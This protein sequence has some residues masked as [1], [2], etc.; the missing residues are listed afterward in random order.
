M[1]CQQGKIGKTKVLKKLEDIEAG[2]SGEGTSINHLY[3][4][5]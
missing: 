5:L 4:R 1:T 3:V 2:E